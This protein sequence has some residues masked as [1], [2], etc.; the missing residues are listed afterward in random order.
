[1]KA[2]RVNTRIKL[3]NNPMGLLIHILTEKVKNKRYVRLNK[4]IPGT[5]SIRKDRS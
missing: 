3:S 4:E 5:S 2:L 1:M